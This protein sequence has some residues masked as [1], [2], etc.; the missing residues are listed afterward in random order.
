MNEFNETPKPISSPLPA[1][2]ALV[3]QFRPPEC[4]YFMVDVEQ[5]GEEE[6]E[7]IPYTSQERLKRMA[8]K[9][10]LINDLKENLGLELDF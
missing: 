10:P 6:S 3:V 1:R 7:G 9:N 8:E 2:R 4:E 5:S